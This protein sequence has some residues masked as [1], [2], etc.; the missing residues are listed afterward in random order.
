MRSTFDPFSLDGE[1]FVP[2]G[3][4]KTSR[5]NFK[6]AS[7]R[8]TRRCMMDR[9]AENKNR[10]RKPP[11]VITATKVTRNVLRKREEERNRETRVTYG[12]R[13]SHERRIN[14]VE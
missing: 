3:Q 1:N 11:R 5:R 8:A 10:Q 6:S 13:G 14:S 9:Q 4:E 2:I 7:R 12:F